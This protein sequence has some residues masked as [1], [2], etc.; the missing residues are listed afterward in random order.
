MEFHIRKPLITLLT[1]IVILI[2][3]LIALQY[4]HK[5]SK[6]AV[7]ILQSQKLTIPV[8]LQIPAIAVNAA[9]Q[10]VSVNSNGAME[11]PTN[12]I[13]VGW[14][15]L[16]PKPGERGSAVI[17]GHVDDKFGKAGV[18]ANLYKLKTGDKIVVSDTKHVAT[19]FIV[20]ESRT[21]PPGYAEEVFSRSD[22]SYLNLIT[23]DGV[24]DGSKKSYSKRLVVFAD[25]SH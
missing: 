24:W 3:A 19:V 23:C 11:V 14:F 16:G 20:R 15:S 4:T 17:A 1:E 5:E 21:Y 8:H 22:H 13:D 6:H 12:S 25:S 9:I 2:V 10:S 7:V 18:F